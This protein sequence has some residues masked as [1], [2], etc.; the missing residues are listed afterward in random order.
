MYSYL[1]YIALAYSLVRLRDF[2]QFSVNIN[3]P[4]EVK[5]KT[6]YKLRACTD[7]AMRTVGEGD[8]RQVG[9]TTREYEAPITNALT[10]SVHSWD[11]D[12]RTACDRRKKPESAARQVAKTTRNNQR[13]L[14]ATCNPREVNI[15]TE[16]HLHSFAAASSQAG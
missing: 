15:G 1:W 11:F 12:V 13:R 10:F 9:R 14:D 16:K 4:F 3:P 6:G 8:L 7:V 5:R 2:C